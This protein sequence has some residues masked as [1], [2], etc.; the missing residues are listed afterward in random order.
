M[1]TTSLS[2]KR[3]AILATDGVEQSELV[4]V[5]LALDAAGAT[6]HLIS[7]KS[8]HIQAVKHHDKG[9][10]FPVDVA[11]D[12]ANP[13]F[14]V[15]LD[16]LLEA[17]PADVGGILTVKDTRDLEVAAVHLSPLRDHLGRHG[18]GPGCAGGDAGLRRHPHPVRQ[19]DRGLPAHPEEVRRPGRAAAAD[20]VGGAPAR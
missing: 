18:G 2:G 14:V 1:T 7:P 3:V 17:I 11:L 6:T 16:G 9:D 4:D 19:T 12:A 5:R 15:P 8:G 20:A 10:S 13:G